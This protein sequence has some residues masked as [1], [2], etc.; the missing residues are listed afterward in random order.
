MTWGGLLSFRAPL[1]EHHV[2]TD[3]AKGEDSA[4]DEGGKVRYS[5]LR[6]QG[7][8]KFCCSHT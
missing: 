1:C 2:D 4:E 8:L 6:V 5:V 7:A 3:R